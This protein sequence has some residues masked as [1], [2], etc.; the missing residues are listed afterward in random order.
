MA[1]SPKTPDF[2]LSDIE[3]AKRAVDKPDPRLADADP[4]FD[5][6]SGRK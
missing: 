4:A 6:T 1:T 3:A 2:I 5:D